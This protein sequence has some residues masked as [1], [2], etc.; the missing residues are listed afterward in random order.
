MTETAV[1]GGGCFWCTEAVFRR[2]RG[3]VRVTSGYAGGTVMN[4]G[5]E[6]VTTGSTGHAEVVEVEYDPVVIPYETLLSVFWEIHDPTSVNRQ[7]ADVG[8]QYRSIILTTQDDQLRLAEASKAAL[9]DHLGKTVATQIRT[10][11][12][13]WPAEEYHREYF[14]RNPGYPYCS[15]VIR[16]K[17]E[18][19]GNKFSHLLK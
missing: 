9:E 2:I 16:P 15:A 7:G 6:A 17:L 3:V 10:L 4:P 8:T 11:D 12:R 18:K 13:F 14:D 5:Y 19:A 1:F